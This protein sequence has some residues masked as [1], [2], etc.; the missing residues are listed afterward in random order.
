VKYQVLPTFGA[1]KKGR[2][3]FRVIDRHRKRA[4]AGP[5]EPDIGYMALSFLGHGGSAAG[6]YGSPEN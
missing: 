3:R 6:F 2:K 4:I 1:R 5:A